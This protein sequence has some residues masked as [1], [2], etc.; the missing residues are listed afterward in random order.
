M[1]RNIKKFTLSAKSDEDT[2]YLNMMC[3]FNKE[4]LKELGVKID[5]HGKMP[6]VVIY[7][8]KKDWIIILGSYLD[9]GQ[10]TCI[11]L[12][13]QMAILSGVLN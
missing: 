5:S 2:A 9:A 3:Y 13:C 8:P 10:E 7:Y 12:C 11:L 1:F 4:E 6:D